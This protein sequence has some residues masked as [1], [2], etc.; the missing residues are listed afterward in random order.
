MSDDAPILD[1]SVP[2]DKPVTQQEAQVAAPQEPQVD[3]PSSSKPVQHYSMDAAEKIATGDHIHLPGGY[4]EQIQKTLSSLPNVNMVDNPE[5]RNWAESMNEGITLN[6]YDGVFIPTLND[7]NAT[8]TQKVEHNNLDLIAA[9]PRFKNVENENL[10]GERAVIRLISHLGIGTLFQVPLWHSGVWVTFK[11]PTESEIVEI[12]RLLTSEKIKFGRYSYG[13]AFSNVT[14]YTT[15]RLVEFA[16][17]HIYDMT[18][19]SDEVNIGNLK[20]HISCQ[21]IP[22]LLWGFVCTMYPR[23]FKYSRACVNNPDKCN[24]I[25][26]DTLNLTKLQWTNTA[27]L[28]DWQKTHMS[29]RQ[30]RVKDLASIKRYKEELKSSQKTR[31]TI[32]NSSGHEVSVTV[33]TP[34][35]SE[36]I[37]AGHRWIGNI[38]EAV[39]TAVG[40]DANKAERDAIIIRH[41]QASAMRNYSHWVESIEY[42]SNIVDDRETIESLLD[43]LSSDDEIREKFIQ[44]VVKF[45]NDSTISVIGIP[46]F[47]CPKCGTEQPGTIS[48]PK[49]TNV[50]PLDVI[51]V[52]FEL[53]TQRLSRLTE[54]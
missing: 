51:Q 53:I 21:D 42:D 13:L 3:K 9:K 14:V 16:L 47:D 44:E 23:G 7:P 27:G 17:S 22:S 19:M 38:V 36:Y 45:I 41:G 43:N 37:D 48:L 46:T 11:P 33:R 39:E 54:R 2:V 8:F 40:T 24:H 32:S 50:I 10:K 1:D 6:T 35:I 49:I 34:S 52:F 15:N 30:A 20:N 26:E 31:V 18:A 5:A 12:N 29:S 25:A 4:T 28:T